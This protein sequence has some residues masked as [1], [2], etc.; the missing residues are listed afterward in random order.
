MMIDDV[1]V[2]LDSP[3]NDDTTICTGIISFSSMMGRGREGYEQFVS[4][5]IAVYY[6]F[7]ILI[8]SLAKFTIF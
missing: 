3:K 2:L 5:L 6:S 7:R 4:L 1:E 8:G